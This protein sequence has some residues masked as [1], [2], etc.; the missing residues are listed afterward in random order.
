MLAIKIKALPEAAP[1]VQFEVTQLG[2]EAGL[3]AFDRLARTIGPVFAKIG[4]ARKGAPVKLADLLETGIKSVTHADLVHFADVFGKTTRY[5][6]DGGETWPYLHKAQREALFAGDLPLFFAW[7]SFAVETN[8]SGFFDA[9][10]TV[11]G[12]GV[13]GADTRPPSPV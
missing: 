6:L 3:L 13:P 7:L 12:G 8:F 1:R 9:L 4:D 5:S 11:P 10:G 2:F